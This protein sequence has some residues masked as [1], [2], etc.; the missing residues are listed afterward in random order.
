MDCSVTPYNRR[1]SF[2]SR[3]SQLRTMNT[4]KDPCV[5]NVGVN[6]YPLH[7]LPKIFKMRFSLSFTHF[8]VG[9]SGRK[10]HQ[11]R[12][13][14][15]YPLAR[16][17]ARLQTSVGPF[18]AGFHAAGCRR[19]FGRTGHRAQNCAPRGLP[20]ADGGDKGTYPPSEPTLEQNG[21]CPVSTAA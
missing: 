5:L 12:R 18:S 6:H 17:C 20:W 13:L 15:S 3:L 1:C 8:T 16:K 19:V 9:P 11:E 4:D 10:V 21:I 14:E 2:K 7:W